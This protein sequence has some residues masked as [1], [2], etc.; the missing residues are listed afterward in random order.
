[1]SDLLPPSPSAVNYS[2]RVFAPPPSALSSSVTVNEGPGLKSLTNVSTSSLGL[3]R[4]HSPP[5]DS[6]YPQSNGVSSSAISNSAIAS[7]L[8]PAMR[9]LDFS[10][11]MRSHEGTHV[12]LART[13]EDL[14]QWLSVVEVGLSGMLDITSEDL[15][16]T[17]EHE[18]LKGTDLQME[19]F[20]ANPALATET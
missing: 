16:I 17:E 8:G 3:P 14:S 1:M 6:S 19:N 20:R 13:V 7:A 15:T 5:S 2:S 4:T 12:E 10:A 18:D 9:P 11:L